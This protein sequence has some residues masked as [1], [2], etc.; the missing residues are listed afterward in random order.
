MNVAG[1]PTLDK[2]LE[3]LEV[4]ASAPD[5]ERRRREGNLK[6]VR[7]ISAFEGVSLQ[8]LPRSRLLFV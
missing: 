6:T 3:R 1:F 5:I 2:T 8:N 4:D 7:A